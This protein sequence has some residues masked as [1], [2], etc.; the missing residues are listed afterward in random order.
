MITVRLFEGINKF[1]KKIRKPNAVGNNEVLDFLS[2]IPSDPELVG[3]VSFYLG[4]DEG[5]V[6]WVFSPFKNKDTANMRMLK[7]VGI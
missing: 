2:R 5:E 4:K 7:R 3:T 1:T 6:Y